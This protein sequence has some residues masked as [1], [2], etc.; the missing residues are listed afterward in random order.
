MVPLVA[1]HLFAIFLVDPGV[2]HQGVLSDTLGLKIDTPA[3]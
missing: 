3:S 1:L 2:S